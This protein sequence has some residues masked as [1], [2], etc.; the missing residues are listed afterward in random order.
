MWELKL[1]ACLL[2]ASSLVAY[3]F[4]VINH[5]LFMTVFLNVFN[6]IALNSS[7]NLFGKLKLMLEKIGAKLGILKVE[8]MVKVAVFI[9]GLICGIA[10]WVGAIDYNLALKVLTLVATILASNIAYLEY[11][12]F[13]LEG[14]KK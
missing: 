6:F 13:M 1:I 7:Q 2:L 5:D 10:Y 12:I 11:K 9:W 8:P 14:E 4:G 3:I